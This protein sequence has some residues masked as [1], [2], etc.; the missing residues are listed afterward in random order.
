[1]S[2]VVAPLQLRPVDVCVQHVHGGW[3]VLRGQADAHTRERRVAV[4][5]LLAGH[6]WWAVL[7]VY[8][9]P[10]CRL[11]CLSRLFGWVTRLRWL[12]P[13]KNLD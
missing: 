6:H 2:L 11:A 3:A 9:R 8:L 12:C 10:L 4:P 13:Y 7:D 5:V 1:M